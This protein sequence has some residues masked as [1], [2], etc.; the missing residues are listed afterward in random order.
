MWKYI[1]GILNNHEIRKLNINPGSSRGIILKDQFG[2]IIILD[3][4]PCRT[5]S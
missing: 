2:N 3:Y 1:S 5:L 4:L